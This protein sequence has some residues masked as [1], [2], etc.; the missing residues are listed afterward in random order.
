MAIRAI[1]PNEAG[2]M[3]GC[4]E[5]REPFFCSR[6]RTTASVG[7]P[8][9][10]VVQD[11]VVGP[12]FPAQPWCGPGGDAQPTHQAQVLGPNYFYQPVGS[13]GPVTSRQ[14]LPAPVESTAPIGTASL[15]A[16]QGPFSLQAQWNDR[17]HDEAP[18]SVAW[19]GVRHKWGRRNHRAAGPTAGGHRLCHAERRMPRDD[20]QM[21]LTTDR[22]SASVGRRYPSQS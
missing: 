6:V 12:V 4:G 11:R 16:S 19:G 10:L 14:L 17:D 18:K 3:S 5:E 13:P 20:P 15:E 8:L 1:G 9:V 22:E 21:A 7:P 2:P